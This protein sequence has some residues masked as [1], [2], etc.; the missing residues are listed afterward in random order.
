MK[1]MGFAVFVGPCSWR[2]R[3]KVIARCGREEVW[4]MELDPLLVSTDTLEEA[5][6]SKHT[7]RESEWARGVSQALE[8]VDEGLQAHLTETADAKQLIPGAESGEKEPSPTQERRVEELRKEVGDCLE[9]VHALQDD[10]KNAFEVF[11]PANGSPA[12]S[13]PSWIPDFG[14]IRVRGEQLIL[15]VMEYMRNETNLVLDAV[16]TD[17]GVGD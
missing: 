17:I 3:R 13:A 1:G 16:T 12:G 2:N 15:A 10:V 14:Q 5:L 6:A 4:E 11:R 7:G 8:S 9:R